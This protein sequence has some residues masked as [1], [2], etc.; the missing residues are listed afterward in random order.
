MKFINLKNNLGE[1]ING[2]VLIEPEVFKAQEDFFMRVGIKNL[3]K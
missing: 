2:P 1:P 3:M